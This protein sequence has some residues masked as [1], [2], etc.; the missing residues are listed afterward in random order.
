MFGCLDWKS[1]NRLG[2]GS[3]ARSGS[4][5]TLATF[6][7]ILACD[8]NVGMLGVP[9]W[10]LP[11]PQWSVKKLEIP[12]QHVP[13]RCVV[14]IRLS[15]GTDEVASLRKG[16]RQ[17]RGNGMR[18]GVMIEGEG[19]T[20]GA[21]PFFSKLFSRANFSKLFGEVWKKS[22]EKVWKKVW[23]PERTPKEHVTSETICPTLS[24]LCFRTDVR[25]HDHV[26][27][28]DDDNIKKSKL[29]RQ[30]TRSSAGPVCYSPVPSQGRL[31]RR[32][33]TQRGTRMASASRGKSTTDDAMAV[34]MDRQ[35]SGHCDSSDN[36]GE[37]GNARTQI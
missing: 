21:E 20:M 22:L 23:K 8:K 14:V 27:V 17:T 7:L 15:Y 25:R 28:Y 12:V 37:A 36:D 24:E 18:E 32:L 34:E 4:K 16:G 10:G 13:S 6:G 31:R 35:S 26:A 11:W 9:P 3:S 2:S 5:W 19:E 33:Q 29:A 1:L 30:P